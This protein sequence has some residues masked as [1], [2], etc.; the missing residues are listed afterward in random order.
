MTWFDALLVLAV[1]ALIALGYKRK[2]SGLIVGLS[3]LLLFKLLL[4]VFNGNSY[5]AL[6]FALVAGLLSGLLSRAIVTRQRFDLLWGILGGVG[7]A[8]LGFL[9]VLSTITSLPIERNLN[10]QVVYPSSL[11]AEPLK[12]AVTN[13]R[14]VKVGRGILLYPLLE[15]TGRIE[16][17]QKGLY[18]ALHDFM[19]VGRPW[20]GGS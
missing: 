13:S 10:N 8:V 14:F 19:V 4:V 2:L 20:E 7:G 9:L 15:S 3:G 1:A 5:I 6:F 16:E 11:M 18:R 12:S 17:S